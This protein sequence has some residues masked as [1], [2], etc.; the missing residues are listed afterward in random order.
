M[1]GQRARAGDF[2]IEIDIFGT[3]GKLLYDDIEF[4]GQYR[5]RRFAGDLLIVFGKL[6]IVIGIGDCIPQCANPL[7]GR[8]RRRDK[9]RGGNS[10]RPIDL[11]Q[12]SIFIGPG[13]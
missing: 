3:P 7:L 4:V 12:P 5:R 1:A 8:P 11:Q 6:G 13:K 9:G 2:F 10:E